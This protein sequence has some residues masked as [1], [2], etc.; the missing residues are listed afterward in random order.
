MGWGYSVRVR[1]GGA[2]ETF[3]LSFRL[4]LWSSQSISPQVS[5]GIPLEVD[6]WGERRR[7]KEDRATAAHVC[8]PSCPPSPPNTHTLQLP[9]ITRNIHTL[10]YAAVCKPATVGL[11]GFLSWHLAIICIHFFFIQRLD[12]CRIILKLLICCYCYC[13]C[14]F[15]KV[16]F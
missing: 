8:F 1:A 15:D 6:G 4:V 9:N 11:L 14:H 7:W 12:R 13:H 16:T 5:F 2:L 10:K 3:L